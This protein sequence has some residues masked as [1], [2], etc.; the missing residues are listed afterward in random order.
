MSIMQQLSELMLAMSSSS[1]WTDA[2]NGDWTRGNLCVLSGLCLQEKRRGRGQYGGNRSG[3]GHKG[4]RQRGT[5]PRLGFEGGATPFY[6][7]IPKY[8]YNEGHR[9]TILSFCHYKMFVCDN[10]VWSSTNDLVTGD[11]NKTDKNVALEV[12]MYTKQSIHN[13]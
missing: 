5:R 1:Q 4:E 3:R 2:N 7:I 11:L 12:H 13:E 10:E 6:L 8:G 9:Y